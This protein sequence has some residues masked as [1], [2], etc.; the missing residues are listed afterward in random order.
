MTY[1]GGF[2][3]NKFHGKAFERGNGYRFEGTY[4]DGAR[5]RGQLKW[6]S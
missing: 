6:S 4:I 1:E 3:N 2:K 5:D